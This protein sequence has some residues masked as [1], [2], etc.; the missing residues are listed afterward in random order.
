M[1]RYINETTITEM[2]LTKDDVKNLY[3]S[4]EFS[5]KFEFDG[6]KR[7]A[8]RQYKLSFSFK[9][10]YYNQGSARKYLLTNDTRRKLLIAMNK[11]CSTS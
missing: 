6:A 3:K 4:L 8:Y 11:Q 5:T 1:S 7:D 9:A 10:F 2:N